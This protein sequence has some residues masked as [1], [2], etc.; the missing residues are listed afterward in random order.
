VEIADWLASHELAALVERMMARL[1]QEWRTDQANI[2]DGVALLRAL[3][4]VRSL[5]GTDVAEVRQ[6]VQDAILNEARSGCRAD[7]LHELL[8][9]LD[10]SQR[11]A[12]A[13]I[14]ALAES[15]TRFEQHQF[16]EELLECRSTEQFDGLIDDLELFRSELSVDVKRLI[17]WVE[18][19][20]AE[21]EDHQSEQADH[22]YDEWKERYYLE[23][24]SERDISE[25]FS[26]LRTDQ[27]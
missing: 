27:D 9:V 17:E 15:F 1:V 19:A 12:P 21:F 7:E 10:T 24:D 6:Q 16:R 5:P 13:T 4:D 22:M 14:A 20:K 18:E 11:S 23:R 3:G 8:S 25:L 2:N 26:S